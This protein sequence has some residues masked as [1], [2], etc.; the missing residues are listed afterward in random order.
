MW[1]VVS[2]RYVNDVNEDG[3]IKLNWLPSAFQR[4]LNIISFRISYPIEP[5]VPVEIA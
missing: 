2:V 1:Y 3:I 5:G 4:K